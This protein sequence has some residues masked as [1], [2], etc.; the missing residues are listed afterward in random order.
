MV[1]G[2]RRRWPWPPQA[3]FPGRK[4][5]DALTFCRGELVSHLTDSITST[6]QQLGDAMWASLGAE[7]GGREAHPRPDQLYADAP[8][9]LLSLT[10]WVHPPHPPYRLVYSSVMQ[11]HSRRTPHLM[12]AHYL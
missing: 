9:Q 10:G 6:P 3:L 12:L 4:Q 5:L 2:I 7:G 1:G 8:K 11:I